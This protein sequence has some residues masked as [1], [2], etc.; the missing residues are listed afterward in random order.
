ME[1]PQLPSL[2]QLEQ[3]PLHPLLQL[4]QPPLPPL[5]QVEQ[6]H[7]LHPME[8][9]PQQQLLD[10]ISFSSNVIVI[11]K[12]VREISVSG[13]P[14]RGTIERLGMLSGTISI[15]NAPVS[16][17]SLSSVLDE[18][19]VSVP[20]ERQNSFPSIVIFVEEQSETDVLVLTS[21][22]GLCRFCSCGTFCCLSLS[23]LSILIIILAPLHFFDRK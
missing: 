6:P 10:D 7:R 12:P 16:I 1:Q 17:V 19:P 13:V 15:G 8:Q 23:L 22:N 20:I 4:E 14:V 2:L 3:P 21:K 18:M 9:L 5:L 11:G